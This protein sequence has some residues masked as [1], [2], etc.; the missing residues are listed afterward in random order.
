[1]T[2]E[3]VCPLALAVEAAYGRYDDIYVG[4]FRTGEVNTWTRQ[5]EYG[6][7]VINGDEDINLVTVNDCIEHIKEVVD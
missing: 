4:I 6:I 7:Q 5:E 2:Y 3:V 1:M